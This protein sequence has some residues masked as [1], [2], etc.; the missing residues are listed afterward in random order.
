MSASIRLLLLKVLS[1]VY[2]PLVSVLVVSCQ[3]IPVWMLVV[4][5]ALALSLFVL[6]KHFLRRSHLN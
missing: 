3:S 6:F 4:A 1:V 5:V 2:T